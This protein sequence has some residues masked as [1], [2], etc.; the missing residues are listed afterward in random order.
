MGPVMINAKNCSLPDVAGASESVNKQEFPA[1]T[2]HLVKTTIALSGIHVLARTQAMLALT[3]SIAL[4]KSFL[5]KVA[6]GASV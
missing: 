1:E 4:S 5:D 2:L 6:T 3:T